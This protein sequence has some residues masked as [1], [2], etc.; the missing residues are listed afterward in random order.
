MFPSKVR[1][2]SGQMCPSKVRIRSGWM[3]E[4]GWTVVSFQ[5][6][7]RKNLEQAIVPFQLNICE[8]YICLNGLLFLPLTFPVLLF[9]LSTPRA[10]I[11]NLC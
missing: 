8:Y 2:R 6:E 7:V 5:Y 9:F 11:V 4:L 3:E 1:I 10:M